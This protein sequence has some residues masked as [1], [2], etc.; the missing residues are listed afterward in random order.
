MSSPNP[1]P[2]KINRNKLM[3]QRGMEKMSKW[4]K[5]DRVRMGHLSL[6]GWY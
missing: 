1:N 6:E 2:I 4:I 3:E 5:I